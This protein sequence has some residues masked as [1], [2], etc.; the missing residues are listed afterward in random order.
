MNA[1]TAQDLKLTQPSEGKGI[2]ISTDDN[3]TTNASDES[4]NYM[5]KNKGN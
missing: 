2:G 4:I 5:L 1:K 3:S